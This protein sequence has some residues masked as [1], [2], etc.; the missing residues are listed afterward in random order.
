MNDTVANAA[1]TAEVLAPKDA[2]SSS[3]E[4]LHL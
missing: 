2:A 4:F 1:T 3:Q